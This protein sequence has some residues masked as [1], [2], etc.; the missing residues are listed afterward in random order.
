MFD[1]NVIA[2][3]DKTTGPL[4][5]FDYDICRF[6]NTQEIFLFVALKK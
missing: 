2:Y 5:C 6:V 1:F 3:F 4:T